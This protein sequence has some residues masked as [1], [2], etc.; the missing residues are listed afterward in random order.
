MA[1]LRE[2][3]VENYLDEDFMETLI[4][5][6]KKKD[7]QFGIR[8]TDDLTPQKLQQ[9]MRLCVDYKYLQE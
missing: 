9:P 6:I 3:K 7:K 4:E 2:R 1:Q 5:K 8:G